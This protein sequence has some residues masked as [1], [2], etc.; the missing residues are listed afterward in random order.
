MSRFLKKLTHKYEFLK[1]EL[2]EVK[3]EGD[4]YQV[5]W[6]QLFGKYFADKNSEFWVNEDT[7]ELR[8]DR[9]ED[10]T[11]TDEIEPKPEKPKKLR[12]LYKKL[13]KHT[14]P[15]KGGDEDK[16]NKVKESYDREDL[17]A[18]LSLAGQYNIDFDIEEEDQEMVEKSCF[19]IENEINN[20]KSTLSWAY[21]T[22][23]R[24]KKKAVLAMMEQQFNITI[25]P[26]DI[27]EELL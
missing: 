21:F 20:T 3:E 26:K 12:D 24:S 8:K 13:S 5:K 10:E 19:N 23:D 27:P 22:G 7:G 17:L 15:D 14:H 9:P 2:E 16:F 18:L 4:D 6:G 11:D 25:D 1:L